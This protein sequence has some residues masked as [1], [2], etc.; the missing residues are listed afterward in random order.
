MVGLSLCS[1]DQDFTIKLESSGI[2]LGIGDGLFPRIIKVINLIGLISPNGFRQENNSHLVCH[3][4]K[5]PIQ[6][7]CKAVNI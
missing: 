3:T 1:E 4:K 7:N 6:K 2:S 5:L